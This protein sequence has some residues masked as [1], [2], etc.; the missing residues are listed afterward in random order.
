MCTRFVYFAPAWEHSR[1]H[2]A[3][4]VCKYRLAR[5]CKRRARSRMVGQGA[6]HC[7]SGA[8]SRRTW[9]RQQRAVRRYSVAAALRRAPWCRARAT[10]RCGVAGKPQRRAVRLRT[11]LGRRV[12]TPQLIS[13]SQPPACQSGVDWRGLSACPSA[14]QNKRSDDTMSL[15]TAPSRPLQPRRRRLPL[16]TSRW[17]LPPHRRSMLS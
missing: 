11:A 8:R 6:R 9:P 2:G 13:V 10:S 7:A 4:P 17:S 1:T 16:A 15:S 3:S 5:A 12:W 14:E